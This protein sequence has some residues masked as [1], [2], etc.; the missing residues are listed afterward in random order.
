M[1]IP[2]ALS[3]AILGGFVAFGLCASALYHFYEK[4]VIV[5]PKTEPPDLNTE[6]ISTP[7][8]TPNEIDNTERPLVTKLPTSN[9]PNEDSGFQKR[10]EATAKGAENTYTYKVGGELP[11]YNPSW[12]EC[13]KTEFGYNAKLILS[14]GLGSDGLVK[15]LAECFEARDHEPANK[16]YVYGKTGKYPISFFDLPV[17]EALQSGE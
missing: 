11:L 4:G 3:M 5:I 6:A 14:D 9:E 17:G 12:V 7:P 10:L 1:R 8:E 2:A 16:G 13:E 15:N